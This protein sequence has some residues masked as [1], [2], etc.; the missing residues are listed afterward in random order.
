MST[1]A[2]PPSGEK[3]VDFAEYVD[4]QLEKARRQIKTTDLLTAA[5]VA[6]VFVLAYLLLFVLCDHWLIPGGVPYWARLVGLVVGLVCLGTWLGLKLFW[7]WFKMVS[8]LF[9]A[10]EVER[11]EPGLRNNLLNWVD[12][13]RAGRPVDP[14]VLRAIERRAAVQLTKIDVAQA[15]DHRPLLRSG[16][17]LLAT[18]ALFCIYT[19]WSPKSVGPS[20]WRVLPLTETPAPTRTVIRDV[21]PGDARVLARS[22]LEVTVEL[23]GI[24]PPEVKLLYT[25]EDL[26]FQNEPVFLKPD[27][28]GSP[29]FRGLLAG[30][31]G[32][33]LLRNL[34]Y[35]I[36]AGDAVSRSYRVVVEQ[37]PS[38]KVQQARIIPPAYTRL[39]EDPV[40]GGNFRGWEGSQVELTATANMPVHT[41][42]VQF[43]DEPNGK[44]TGEEEPVLISEGTQLVSRWKL[45]FRA[46]GTYPKYYRL[47]CQTADGRK[48]PAPLVYQYDILRDLPPEIALLSPD[49]DVTLPANAVLPLLAEARDP[50]FEL[51]PVTLHLEREGQN[52]FRETLLTGGTS[53]ARITYDLSLG[54]LNL[55][56]GDELKLYLE[57]QD[58]RQPRRNRRQTPPLR[59]H[60]EEPTTPQRVQEQLAA[61]KQRQQEVAQARDAELEKKPP[62]EPPQ[63]L[64]APAAAESQPSPSETAARPA[65]TQPGASGTPQV[66]E[67]R[68]EP[69]AQGAS[70]RGSA[71][72]PQA[73]SAP[74]DSAPRA[75]DDATER[76]LS[77]DGEDDQELLRRL[78]ER[79]MSQ[80]MAEQDQTPTGS[81][82]RGSQSGQPSPAERAPSPPGETATSADAPE[83]APPEGRQS[84]PDP[85]RGESSTEPAPTETA[86]PGRRGPQA[87]QPGTPQTPQGVPP[88][89]PASDTAPRPPS[90]AGPEQA[91]KSPSES[92]RSPAAGT[93]RS[94]PPDGAEPSTSPADSAKPTGAP[95][96][97]TAPTEV[98][99][100]PSTSP[101]SGQ[102]PP[103][104]Q[105][106]SPATPKPG[107][108]PTTPAGTPTPPPPNSPQ[109]TRPEPTPQN[110]PANSGR[111]AEPAGAPQPQQRGPTDSNQPSSPAESEAGQPPTPRRQP[112]GGQPEGPDEPSPGPGRKAGQRSEQPQTGEQGGSQQS[113]T[114]NTG[115]QEPGPGETTTDPRAPRD[116]AHNQAE[117]TSSPPALNQPPKTPCGQCAGCQSG[118]MCEHSGQ[119]AGQAKTSPNG[120]GTRSAEGAAPTG[121][122]EGAPSGSA[123]GSQPGAG[124][125]PASQAP[126]GG[127]QSSA[128]DTRGSEAGPA[129]G[130]SPAKPSQ[131]GQPQAG[132]QG[133]GQAQGQP[134]GSEQPPPGQ[135]GGNKPQPGQSGANPGGAG[136][137]L[138][139]PPSAD[140]QPPAGDQTPAGGQPGAQGQ[141]SAGQ[142][143]EQPAR[144]ASQP[145][146]ASQPRGGNQPG[147]GNQPSQGANQGP[148]GGGQGQPAS[149]PPNGN[150][151]GQGDRAQGAEGQGGVGSS[152]PGPSVPQF[153]NQDAETGP[154]GDE[155]NAEFNRQAAELILQRLQKQLERGDV[156]PELLKELGWTEAEMRRF[157]ERL[158]QQ[159]SSP[160]QPTPED[161]V[162]RLQFEEMLK[163]LDLRRSGAKR[164]A[165]DVPKRSVEQVDSR[166]SQAPAEYRK[167]WE[168]Y[169]RKLLEQKKTPAP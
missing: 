151:L 102:E 83:P 47:Q 21:K 100:G 131:Q 107:E 139:G 111:P 49:D 20:L 32:Q 104:G 117:K 160:P 119:A 53:S 74:Q 105:P 63:E 25:T 52:L 149:G 67:A 145:G 156:D 3:Y 138:G 68:P 91:V 152:Q 86:P 114:G 136:Q 40:Q 121:K 123:Q 89:E 128:N 44:P 46:D 50:D 78:H 84:R 118:G 37:P 57:A 9:A 59:I 92:G 99:N 29:R 85:G 55:K 106:T 168:T 4:Y 82:A 109:T 134:P 159:L 65:E 120:A 113:S 41:A 163:S 64:P 108:A 48:D 71:T 43:L 28:E 58:N 141:P 1:V 147:G 97:R 143:P 96:P 81:Q 157:V 154:A 15:I 166:R 135:P 60:I 79:L 94:N 124:R 36:E 125:T 7:P 98:P 150:K 16:Y 62:T 30:E 69:S 126:T 90:Q 38:A 42:T 14:A 161:E 122:P 45:Q 54:V 26:K 158:S 6:A 142:S 56:P 162:R 70:S 2:E 133:S 24:I 112:T 129:G 110:Q 88:S 72:T 11:S 115:R 164:T 13:Q 10:K 19:L 127:E 140:G 51:G 130:A 34:H 76:P 35:R 39:P 33:G 27:L 132:Q 12:L 8:G 18:V 103:G 101:P 31:Q 23:G 87:D 167:A 165:T 116:P 80:P 17:A 137:Q 61:W 148:P 95:T 5:T 22:M 155:A 144:E 169:T 73:E 146:A 93:P 153:G 77:P 66:A 75:P